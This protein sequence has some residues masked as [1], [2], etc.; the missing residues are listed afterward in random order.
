MSHSMEEVF[1]PPRADYIFNTQLTSAEWSKFLTELALWNIM[2]RGT[3]KQQE[4][5][6]EWFK[7]H[8][9]AV[10]GREMVFRIIRE[11]GDKV[12]FNVDVQNM[13][14]E[15]GALNTEGS[16]LAALKLHSLDQETSIQILTQMNQ[17]LEIENA[18]L[19][20][21]NVA[22]SHPDRNRSDRQLSFRDPQETPPG[23]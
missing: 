11:T 3:P 22:L 6:R 17:D 19:R 8:F 15:T 23:A 2:G 9:I 5:A 18:R 20:N 1:L 21:E 7:A 13:V 12:D 10:A 16:E 4:E 14:D